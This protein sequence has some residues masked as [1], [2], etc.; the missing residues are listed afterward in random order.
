MSAEASCTKYL[1]ALAFKLSTYY[2]FKEKSKLG[3][4]FG[5]VLEAIKVGKKD[6]NPGWNENGD[7]IQINA[8]DPKFPTP[9]PS[10]FTDAEWAKLRALNKSTSSRIHSATLPTTSN[11]KAY[12]IIPHSEFNEEM[13]SFLKNIGVKATLFSSPDDLEVKDEDLLSDSSFIL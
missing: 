13:V 1:V 12:V 2:V 5:D 8:G 4:T 11:G 10:L 6:K 9:L 3:A 7:M